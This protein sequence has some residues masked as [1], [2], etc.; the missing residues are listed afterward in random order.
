MND[1][2]KQEKIENLKVDIIE[3]LNGLFPLPKHPFNMENEGKLSYA[4]WQFTKGAKALEYFSEYSNT[5]EMFQ[6][7]T[8]LDIGCGPAGKSLYYATQGAQKVIGLDIL[9]K[10]KSSA[11]D[12]AKELKLTNKFSFIVGDSANIPLDSN[13]IDTVIINDAMEHVENPL[14]TIKESLRVLKKG[15]KLYI[16]FPPYFHPYG[17]HLSDAI[18]MPWVHMIF[19]EETLIKAYKKQV[20]DLPDGVDRINFRISEKNGREHFSYINKMTVH[21]FN[22]IL[23]KLNINP[24]YYKEVPLKKA[25]SPFKKVPYVREM[26]IKMVVCVIE[27]S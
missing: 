18:S 9:D 8:V 12:L 26:L 15:G 3:D 19:N 14:K 2:E 23:D 1:L 16:N 27:K 10:Y 25:L 11:E 22:N 4:K 13:S 17:A 24:D 21:R 6:N 5:L 7:K 20:K